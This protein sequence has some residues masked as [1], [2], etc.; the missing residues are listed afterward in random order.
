M[1]KLV[2]H[3]DQYLLV[4]A[5]THNMMMVP[6]VFILFTVRVLHYYNVYYSYICINSVY[7]VHLYFFKS[8]TGKR[9]DLEQ[10]LSEREVF[11]FWVD[12]SNNLKRY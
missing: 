2:L 7:S 8:N 11:L 5:Q 4:T 10:F 12:Q 1:W 6:E 3:L 9:H